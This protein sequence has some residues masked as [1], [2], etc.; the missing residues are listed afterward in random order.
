[1]INPLPIWASTSD[2][3]DRARLFTA[4]DSCAPSSPKFCTV[5]VL[6]LAAGVRFGI[7]KLL[8][9]NFARSSCRSN[10]IARCWA[11]SIW[12]WILACLACLALTWDSGMNSLGLRR[13]S[14]RSRTLK[15]LSSSWSWANSISKSLISCCASCRRCKLISRC[16][17]FLVIANSDTSSGISIC[18]KSSK[19][20]TWRCSS[21]SRDLSLSIARCSLSTGIPRFLSR[22][23]S[24][25][26]DWAGLSFSSSKIALDSERE[27][28]RFFNHNSEG[29]LIVCNSILSLSLSANPCNNLKALL[30]FVIP[31]TLSKSSTEAILFSCK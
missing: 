22:C 10:S 1:M 7:S 4:F 13:F 15:R 20:T 9:A 21:K 8:S 27:N 18:G 23:L 16:F 26:Q 17:M 11:F 24:S 14:L 25:S 30:F 6:V 19:P 29:V 31:L 3:T 5:S 12:D 28:P 2:L